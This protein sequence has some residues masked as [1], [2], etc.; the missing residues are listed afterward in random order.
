MPS[1]DERGQ[2]QLVGRIARRE[3]LDLDGLAEPWLSLAR[4]GLQALEAGDNPARA[5]ESA[6]E[7]LN[8]NIAPTRDLFYE[9]LGQL[10]QETEQPVVGKDLSDLG[11]A[12][13]F[14]AHHSDQVRWCNLWGRWLIWDGMRWKVDDS[15]EINRRAAK[16][17][18]MLRCELLKKAN[19]EEDERKAKTLRNWAKTSRMRNGLNAMV[20][21]ARGVPEYRFIS[22][23][24]DEFDTDPWLLNCQNGTVDLR[25]GKLQLQRAEDLCTQL[26]PIAYDPDA[27]A[28]RWEKF[29]Q[30]IFAGNEDLIKYVQRAAGYSLTG[31][32]SEQCLI[33]LYGGGENGKST[34]L[35]ALQNTMGEYARTIPADSLLIG[36]SKIPNDIAALQPARLVVTGEPGEG[37]YLAE[38][39]V[40]ALT[41]GDK[42]SAR[43][44]HGEWFEYWPKFKIW[45]MANHK[46]RIVGTD[47]GIWRRIHLV[48]FNV[49]FPPEKREEGLDETLQSQL[50]GILAWA[51][52]GCLE[53]QRQG[54]N[55]PSEVVQ[56]TTEYR[57][58]Q[59]AMGDFYSDCCVFTD[60]A[61]ASAKEL[62]EAYQ[63][64]AEES[65]EK[66]MSKRGFGLKLKQRGLQ[67]DRTGSKRSWRGIGL[68]TKEHQGSLDGLDSSP[69]VTD[70]A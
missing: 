1:I 49:K 27:S 21:V 11:N 36:R 66:P 48:P 41:G 50:P 56:A 63:K 53:W 43:F 40:K 46:P 61:Q 62:Y 59:D 23:S 15:R 67:Q 17:A 3:R 64:W 42:V 45:M 28:P 26:V 14:L 13:F 9:A 31:K 58:E 19:A 44:M 16:A 25:S 70:D 7:K 51:V 65:Q 35:T 57:E 22:V 52:K 29:L 5:I 10:D 33:F 20:D 47:D 60:G 8:G 6:I 2:A 32:T 34:F 55:P 37:Q 39:Y 68:K 30:E 54:L 24:P 69:S 12:R 4:A 18:D 38:S